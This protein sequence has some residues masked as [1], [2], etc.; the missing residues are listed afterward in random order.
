[1]KKGKKAVLGVLIS[2]IL[3]IV[4]GVTNVVPYFSVIPDMVKVGVDYISL[5]RM[6]RKSILLSLPMKSILKRQK[7]NII[8]A[9]FPIT[10]KSFQ[11][12]SLQTQMLFAT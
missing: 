5:E 2:V 1:M 12:M 8:R 7:K 3:V 6:Q 9:I 4:L 11:P 10:Q